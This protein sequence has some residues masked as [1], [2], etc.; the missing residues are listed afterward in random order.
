DEHDHHGPDHVD[1]DA[2]PLENVGDLGVGPHDAQEGAYHRRSGDHDQRTEEQRYLRTEVDD[3]V[4]GGSTTQPGGQR[5]PGDQV[6]HHLAGFAQ[7]RETQRE[8]TFE[9]DQSYGQGDKREEEAGG[10]QLRRR[11]P[12]EDRA[13]QE[14]GRQQREDGRHPHAPRQPLGTDAERDDRR[15]S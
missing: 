12:A 2:L 4:G 9:E 5:P 1:D 11:Q 3:E 13:D 8:A 6:D 15:E 10:D 14:A 7:L